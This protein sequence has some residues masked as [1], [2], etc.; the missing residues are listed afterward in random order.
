MCDSLNTD[1]K[2]T[3]LSAMV[4]SVSIKGVNFQEQKHIF[5]LDILRTTI[6]FLKLHINEWMIHY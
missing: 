1:K 5:L 3:K 2:K 6:I 4:V